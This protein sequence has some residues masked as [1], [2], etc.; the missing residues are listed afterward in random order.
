VE[1]ASLQPQFSRFEYQKDEPWGVRA[2]L[3]QRAVRPEDDTTPLRAVE[4]AVVTQEMI[5]APEQQNR[6]MEMQ[7]QQSN[8]KQREKSAQDMAAFT[9]ASNDRR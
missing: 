9:N 8:V 2:V 5:E 4:P 1:E 3:K 7:L 6:E